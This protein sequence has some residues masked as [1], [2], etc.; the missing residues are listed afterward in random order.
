M[1]VRLPRA[2]D[3]A[4]PDTNGHRGHRRLQHV[5]LE[6]THSS[7]LIP[8]LGMLAKNLFLM[9]QLLGIAGWHLRSGESGSWKVVLQ[10][11]GMT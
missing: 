7:S 1:V 6:L 9:P 3:V 4:T 8:R 11:S 10:A 2:S 5:R